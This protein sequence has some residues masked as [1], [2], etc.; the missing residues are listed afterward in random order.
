MR[1]NDYDLQ[2]LH[3]PRRD[4]E[5][6]PFFFSKKKRWKEGNGKEWWDTQSFFSFCLQDW[7]ALTSGK[8]NDLRSSFRRRTVEN[9]LDFFS[10][11]QRENHSIEGKEYCSISRDSFHSLLSLLTCHSILFLSPLAVFLPL[12]EKIFSHCP[13][14]RYTLPIPETKDMTSVR[15]SM[16]LKKERKILRMK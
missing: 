11:L 9:F 7:K 2:S 4:T 5:Q 15:E 3:D 13:P 12:Q 16:V 14:V 1:R 8:R 10:F 6:F